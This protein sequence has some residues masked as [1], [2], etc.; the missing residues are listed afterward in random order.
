MLQRP[1]GGVLSGLASLADMFAY[2][3]RHSHYL[4][5]VDLLW[6][7]HHLQARVEKV[8]DETR[9]ART[10]T[11]TVKAIDGG[12][13]S[14]HLVRDLKPGNYLPLGEPQGEFVLPAAVP[15]QPRTACL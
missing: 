10:L 9:D 6:T 7:D 15:V 13:V 14:Q 11:I 8:W 4:E 5:L 2:P 12:R 3:L 1:S